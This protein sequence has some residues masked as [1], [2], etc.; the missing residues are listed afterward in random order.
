MHLKQMF[1][2]L[3]PFEVQTSSNALNSREFW[4]GSTNIQGIESYGKSISTCATPSEFE[5]LFGH[6]F[7]P[8]NSA[9]PRASTG[10]H[11]ER[12]RSFKMTKGFILRLLSDFRRLSVHRSPF[13]NAS[14]TA[15]WWRLDKVEAMDIVNAQL[16]LCSK[17]EAQHWLWVQ[18]WVLQL[19]FHC[20]FLFLSCNMSS[21]RTLQCIRSTAEMTELTGVAFVTTVVFEGKE[22][23]RGATAEFVHAAHG[24]AWNRNCSWNWYAKSDTIT[25]CLSFSLSHRGTGWTVGALNWL[26][27]GCEAKTTVSSC[28]SFTHV[29]SKTE[30]REE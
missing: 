27:H 4:K 20:I 16:L 5:S 10:F 18:T 13:K 25:I 6:G 2:K 23:A 24:E 29:K 11:P 8:W 9:P 30:G 28:F 12:F 17:P 26:R 19:S 15:S 21:F 14:G 7:R 22:A 3:K 1:T